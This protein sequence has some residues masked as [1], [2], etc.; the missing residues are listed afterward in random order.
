MKTANDNLDCAADRR[1]ALRARPDLVIRAQQYGPD[2]YWVV[3]DP[4]SLSYF[5][6]C[7]EEHSILQMLDGRA[8][9][10]EIKRR[11]DDAFAPLEVTFEQLQSFFSR[12][13]QLGLV[14]ADAPGQGEE[15]LRRRAQR[16]RREWLGAISNPLAIRFRGLDPERFLRWAYPKCRWAFSWWFL[17]L[18]M[19]MV[20]GAAILAAV[21]F[22][23]IRSRLPDFHTFFS[24]RNAIWFAA[25]LAMTK[26]L[27]ELGHAMACKHFGGECHE[28]G[29]L[30]LV[31]MPCLYSNVSD[32]WTFSG[33]WQRIA[34][35]AAG[36]AVE[37]VLAGLCT[38]L[39][40][41]S[42][43]GFFH[44]L[45]LSVVVLCSVNTLLL[46]GN[47][48]LR[49]DG[50]YVLADLLAVPNLYQQS[51]ALLARGFRRLCFGVDGPVHRSLPRNRRALLVGYAAA[52][53]V[54]RWV[55]VIAI[56]WFCYRVLQSHRL[57]VVAQVLAV[58]VVAGLLAAPAGNLAA[59]L[60]NP[61]WRRRIQPARAVLTFVLVA[62]AAITVLA[63]PLPCRIHAPAVVQP[64]GAH[65]VYVVAPGTLIDSVRA[66][67]VVEEGEALAHLENLEIRQ[68]TTELTAQRDQQRL[69]L[70]NLRLRLADDPAVAP[71][72][73][74]A[75]Q[76]LADLEE[77]LEQQLRDQERLVLLVPASGTVIPP[78]QQEPQPYAPGALRSWSGD[79]LEA[80][81]R[82]CYLPTG[83]LFC[84]VGDPDR[85]E[86]HLVI[87]QA[88]MAFV[89]KGQQVR[90]ELDELPGAVL[91]G[92]LVELAKI[93]L[94]VAPR[95]LAG[96]SDLPV[97]V[98]Q[99]G[100]P[101][102]A[103]TSYQARVA[104]DGH[105]IPLRIGTRG[106]ARILAHP[107]P[108]GLR[109]Y[110]TLARV[111]RFGR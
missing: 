8:S 53:A 95:E 60:R 55:V 90:L 73:P 10:A 27:H 105:D 75:E 25:A 12:L 49:Y 104:L 45:M 18:C 2:R 103:E 101:R 59:A 70:Q 34:V 17:G 98:D 5:Q 3:K 107:Q 88:D 36:V 99:Q 108:L 68:K 52:S 44:T 69:E 13:H 42:Q 79:P 21:E 33:K 24:A 46:N 93:D 43:P 85:L 41:F 23:I 31:F 94:K 97:R 76:S 111:F 1:I 35:S 81:N 38:F 9:L 19:A 89:R 106:R 57:E 67:Q 65:H 58:V 40:W 102:P 50:Y 74:A 22:D 20:A 61:A 29:V 62:A 14:V 77:Q 15:L 71:E 6:L 37:V 91:R 83:T 86:A 64:Q 39:W 78:P 56:L 11:F 82:G 110:R 4:V 87:D 48:L 84:L 109:W 72:L 80:R 16:G 7:D 54:Y 100:L 51:R 96:R 47:P 66:G 32:A 63:V 92:T 26:G 30:L 28:I